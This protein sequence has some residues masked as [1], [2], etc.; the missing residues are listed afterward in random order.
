VNE[1]KR[2]SDERFREV[3]MRSVEIRDV[4]IREAENINERI[5]TICLK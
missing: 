1:I 2:D 3:L 4:E 5:D